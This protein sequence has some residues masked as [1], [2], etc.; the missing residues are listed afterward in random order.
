MLGKILLA[1]IVLLLVYIVYMQN[2]KPA[3]HGLLRRLWDYVV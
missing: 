2:K 3:H 1:L